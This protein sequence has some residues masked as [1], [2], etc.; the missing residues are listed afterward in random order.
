[1]VGMALLSLVA[2]MHHAMMVNLTGNLP[3][4]LVGKAISMSGDLLLD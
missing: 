1:M 4:P 3:I 2:I